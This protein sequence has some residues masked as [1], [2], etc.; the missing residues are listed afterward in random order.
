MIG[1][2]TAI[3]L[4]VAGLASLIGTGVN[5]W[6][7]QKN[8][9]FNRQEAEKA[10][11]FNAQEAAKARD[12]EERMSNTAVQRRQQDLK[13]AGYN[14]LLSTIEA[15]SVPNA[16]SARGSAAS[17]NGGNIYSRPDIP[18]ISEKSQT[19][20]ELLNEI[21]NSANVANSVSRKYRNHS[22]IA[23]R[24]EL[25]KAIADE[26]THSAVSDLYRGFRK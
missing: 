11:V 6:Q 16:S 5:A 14:D 3:A 22:E 25:V 8:R 26:V 23:N 17:Y 1:T 9:D 19:R 15:A 24:D 13:Q 21:T 2:G 10:R 7:A 18:V 4:G 20:S 12:F